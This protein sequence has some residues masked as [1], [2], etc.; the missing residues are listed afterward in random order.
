MEGVRGY[1]W[2]VFSLAFCLFVA[3]WFLVGWFSSAA[4]A[5]C[6]Q[7]ESIFGYDYNSLTAY[8]TANTI[9]VADRDLNS[10]CTDDAEAHSTAHVENTSFSKQAEAGWHESW[11]CN[12][13]GCHHVWN[14]F[15]EVQIGSTTY[16]GLEAGPGLPDPGSV[17]DPYRWNVQYSSADDAWKFNYDPG[18][19]GGYIQ[20]GPSNGQYAAFAHGYPMGE[21]SR[22]G[23]ASTGASDYLRVLK[24]SPCLGCTPAYWTDNTTWYDT[25]SNWYRSRCTLTSY[26]V[27]KDGSPSC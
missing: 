1:R 22:R 18:A 7:E 16:G 12:L 15:W 2:I 14:A 23:G 25:I 11:S 24:Y 13:A 19:N 10:S 27:L 9:D 6:P 20:F 21:T 17:A 4:L 3:G 5:S 26:K 8:S